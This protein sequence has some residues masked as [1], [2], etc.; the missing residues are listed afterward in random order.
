[1]CFGIN[2][3]EAYESHVGKFIDHYTQHIDAL[4]KALPDTAI[5]VQA[6]LP[7]AERMTKSF[8][9][10]GDT[11]NEKLQEMCSEL[12]VQYVDASFLLEQKLELYDEDGVHPKKAFYPIWLTYF[13]DIAGLS[14]EE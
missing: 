4:R 14:D 12:Q 5:Y 8:Y 2:D 1:M 10:Y 6:L 11:Y 9:Q 13:A 3:I 7:P